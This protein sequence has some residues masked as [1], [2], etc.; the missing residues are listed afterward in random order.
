MMD[1]EEKRKILA[2]WILETDENILNEVEVVYNTYS[3]SQKIS[4]EHKLILDK[5]LKLHKEKPKSG[6][7]W[8]ELKAQ[9]S[10]KYGV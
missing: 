4:D 3:K 5:R 8:Q 9:L 1:L 2:K 6:K 7:D 10:S